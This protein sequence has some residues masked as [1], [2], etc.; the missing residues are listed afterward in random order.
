[1]INA[2]RVAGNQTIGDG[3]L[4]ASEKALAPLAIADG[5][6]MQFVDPDRAAQLAITVYTGADGRFSLYEEGDLR[7]AYKQGTFNRV[8]VRCDDRTGT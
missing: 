8:P 7:T 1:M 6:A 2:Q 4:E 5:S 3:D